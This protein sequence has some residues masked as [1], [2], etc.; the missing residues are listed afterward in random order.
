MAG[1][2]CSRHLRPHERP[3]G[4]GRA[5]RRCARACS[6]ARPG[7]TLELGA[8]TGANAAHYP[9]SVTELVITEPDPHM[10]RRLRDRL[11]GRAAGVHGRGGRDAGRAAAVRRRARST[12]WFPPSSCAPSTTRSARSPR[13][14]G[15][16]S[17]AAGCCCSSTSATPTGRRLAG[18]QD[19]LE[20][21]VGLAS[22]AAVTRTAT[23]GR[24]SP[25]PG[26]DSPAWSA[27]MLPRRRPWSRPAIA[28]ARPR[29]PERV[30]RPQC[31]GSSPL[32]HPRRPGCCR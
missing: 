10:A 28:A 8:G 6:P 31:A 16:C 21:P 25:P 4:E 5:R 13:S 23:P 2:P 3:G 1:S 15:C 22:P 32:Q 30:V 11:A 18:W 12:P 7:R 19:R 29:P 24:P 17:P 9:A 14:P 27:A 20:R 26:F